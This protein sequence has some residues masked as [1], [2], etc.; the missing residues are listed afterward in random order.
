MPYKIRKKG[1]GYKVCKLTGKC[2][3]KEPIPYK[4][5]VSQMRA[6]Q[7]NESNE[8]VQIIIQILNENV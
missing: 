7:A 5:A 6:I 3:S 8:F 4:R 1:K 2:F